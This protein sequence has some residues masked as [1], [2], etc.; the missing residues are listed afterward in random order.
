MEVDD[1]TIDAGTYVTISFL[2]LDT[3]AR[4]LSSS[5]VDGRGVSPACSH[6]QVH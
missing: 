5:I 1:P 4:I 6:F 3:A 2:S